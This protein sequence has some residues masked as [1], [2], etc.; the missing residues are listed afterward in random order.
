[1]VK[2]AGFKCYFRRE[3]LRITETG[4]TPLLK[5]AS[6]GKTD[7]IEYLLEKGADVHA[8]SDYGRGG[9]EHAKSY[10]KSGWMGNNAQSEL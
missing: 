9:M 8:K 10:H 5:L 4:G 6:T 2:N 7:V 1:M 3:I